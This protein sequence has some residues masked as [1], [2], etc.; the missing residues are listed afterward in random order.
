MEIPKR[1]FEQGYDELVGRIGHVFASESG[2]RMGRD[3]IRGL[4]S[5][6]ERKNGWQMAEALGAETP[7]ALQQF[8]YRGRFSADRLRDELRAYVSEKLGQADGILVMD[9]T[10]F[11]KKGEKSCGVQRQY[12]GTA[13]RVENCQIGVF[14]TYASSK[15]HAPID[16]GLY[17]PKGCCEDQKRRDG[18]G[19][20][21]E[22]TFQTKPEMALEM[23]Q[24]ATQAGVPYTWVTGDC[25]YGDNWAIQQWLEKQGK[26]YV[27]CVSGKESFT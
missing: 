6:I 13:G 22:V 3:Y 14:L 5:P 12:S 16:R 19:V 4:M 2:F 18:A 11:I 26:C 24:A 23:I 27:L 10:G 7:Y 25:V 17:L 21:E 8:L 9:E 15:G 20:P 1:E